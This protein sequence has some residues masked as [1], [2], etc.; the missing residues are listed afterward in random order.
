MGMGM[1]MVMV[2]VIVIHKRVFVQ[3]ESNRGTDMV[4]IILLM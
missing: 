3:I 2:M 4:S 1:E